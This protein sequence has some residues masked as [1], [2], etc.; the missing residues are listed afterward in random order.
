LCSTYFQPSPY[1]EV[2]CSIT[3]QS[4]N[5]V[6]QFKAQK[7]W[8]W[9]SCLIWEVL[10]ANDESC[11]KDIKIKF[12]KANSMSGRLN[13]TWHNNKRGHRIVIRLYV[14][15]RLSF[16]LWPV[17]INVLYVSVVRACDLSQIT[18]CVLLV[19]F[20]HVINIINFIASHFI[21]SRVST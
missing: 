14:L 3:W 15:F 10:I 8:K 6:K 2:L 19:S 5:C 1:F 9:Q 12:S 4:E 21:W 7:S 13:S 18:I 11:D 16:I 20:N 17:C